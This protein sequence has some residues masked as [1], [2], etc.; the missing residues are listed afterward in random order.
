MSVIKKL[1]LNLRTK[2]YFLPV[3]FSI[4]SILLAALVI[5]LDYNANA[6]VTILP[7]YT[8]R[9]MGRVILSTVVGCLMTMLTITFSIMMVVLTI[10]GNQLSPR[11]LQDFLEKRVTLRILGYFIGALIFSIIALFAVKSEQYASYVL[12]PA[13]SVLLLIIAVILF[14]YFIHFISKSIQLTLYIQSLVKKSEAIIDNYQRTISENPEI[15][16]CELDDYKSLLSSDAVE[17]AAPHSGFI[18]FYD[19]KKLLA[20][21]KENELVIS[22]INMVGAHVLADEP[23]MKLYNCQR[24]EN[25][26]EF[27]EQLLE[28]VLIGDETNLYEDVGAGTKKL[29]EIAVR[30][31]SP[32][33]NDPGT[34][35]FCIEQLGFLLQKVAK[36]LEAKVYL[37]GKEPR[38]IVQGITFDRLLFQHF[39][40]ITHY[41]KTDIMIIDALLGALILVC[42]DN[43]RGV[44][45]QVWAYSRYL[46][47]KIRVLDYV[48]YEK[49]YIRERYYQL[50]KA[51][52]QK[53]SLDNLF[54]ME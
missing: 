4:F 22:C 51:S 28:M 27:E 50:S 48:E 17:I 46:M 29:V 26:A 2:L 18:Q 19:E 11:S 15:K 7:L 45:E 23:L 37:D 44:R 9:D 24:P 32:G 39:Y 8:S 33:I 40:Q 52:G 1:F 5:Y 13:I 31:L 42:K 12:S 16:T 14:A 41:G 30:A 25:K 43:S 35:V 54:K 38:L 47:R 34:A 20:F 49:K 36:S 21:A 10:Y 6:A 53:L 3:V